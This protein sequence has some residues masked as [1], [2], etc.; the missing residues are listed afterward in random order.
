MVFWGA[1]LGQIWGQKVDELGDF[2][3]VML[4]ANLGLFG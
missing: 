2:S 1:E 3:E 4:G